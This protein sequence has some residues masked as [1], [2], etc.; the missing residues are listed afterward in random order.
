MAMVMRRQWLQKCLGKKARMVNGEIDLLVTRLG[1]GYY[2]NS[3]FGTLFIDQV[4]QQVHVNVTESEQQCFLSLTNHGQ[5]KA[6]VCRHVV[7][8]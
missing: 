7:T 2:Y 8:G 4:M 6:G 3:H 1:E 5:G